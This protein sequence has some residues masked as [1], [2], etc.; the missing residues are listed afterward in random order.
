MESSLQVADLAMFSSKFQGSSPRFGYYLD[1]E[2]MGISC[3]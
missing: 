2:I 1:D 3:K